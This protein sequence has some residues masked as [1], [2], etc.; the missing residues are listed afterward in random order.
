[1]AVYLPQLDTLFLHVPRT[2][3]T[4]VDTMLAGMFPDAVMAGTHRNLDTIRDVLAVPAHVGRVVATVRDEES[5]LESYW[6]FRT[7]KPGVFYWPEDLPF[8]CFREPDPLPD[9]GQWR[10]TV[11]PGFHADVMGWYTKDATD[12]MQ[13]EVLNADLHRILGI[14]LDGVGRINASGVTA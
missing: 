3:G 6:R 8:P 13:Q 4:F 1:M 2:G 7:E 9:Y 10:K 5:W 12:V 11:P 14:E